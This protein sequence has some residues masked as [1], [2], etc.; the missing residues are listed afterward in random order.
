MA[1]LLHDYGKIIFDQQ[2]LV[3]YGDFLRAA[4]ICSEQLIDQE[5]DILGMGHDDIGAYYS[6]RWGLPDSLSLVVNYHHRAFGHLNLP[7][8]QSCLISIISLAN[9]L[10]WILGMGSSD[11]KI[12]PILQPEIMDY[13]ELNRI[14]F[15]DL[16]LQLDKEM[17]QT[18]RL[19]N[20]S[21]PG[22]SQ[23]R[24]NL[25]KTNLKLGMINAT[26]YFD[27]HSSETDPTSEK[28]SD[29]EPFQVLNP[30]K[31]LMDTLQAIHNDFGFDR[32]CVTQ[33]I[34]PS[35]QLKVIEC[36]TPN[37][38][39]RNLTGLCINIGEETKGFIY[40]LR[41]NLPVLIR[42]NLSAEKRILNQFHAREMIVVPFS[43]HSKVM[44]VLC[45]DYC[46]SQK[47]IT[48][49]IFVRLSTVVNE[50]GAAL[51]N[52]LTHRRTKNASMYDP[53]TGLLNSAGMSPILEKYFQKA[54]NGEMD[55]SVVILNFHRFQE[56]NM[57]F[58]DKTR[59]NILRLIGKILR[60]ISR[61][62]DYIA[63]QDND[64]FLA[65]LA[66]TKFENASGFSKRIVTEVEELGRLI[67]ERFPGLNFPLSVGIASYHEHIKNKEELIALAEQ[68]SLNPNPPPDFTTG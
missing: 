53:L 27:T 37:G 14:D 30:K 16:L 64:S 6:V 52:A 38:E 54:C 50:L 28:S 21:F 63:R 7:E 19:Y 10:S 47:N 67:S 25:L 12:P 43:S 9:F 3:N 58:D 48:P 26:Y 45:M 2:A 46:I 57:E 41:N 66:H 13:I 61:S 42:D 22:T 17:E 55:L 59:E 23:F 35:R 44:G 20:F 1:G 11:L 62:S 51:N 33:A 4:N 18:S 60:K 32:I 49:E 68:A 24:T 56:N 34:K 36:L 29:P 8:N 39:T 5:R 40:S 31:I 15:H 65:L